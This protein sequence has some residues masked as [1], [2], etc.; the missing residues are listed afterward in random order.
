MVMLASIFLS[1][2][3]L[4]LLRLRGSDTPLLAV[5]AAGVAGI[6]IL[7]G[8]LEEAPDSF[9]GPFIGIVLVN[10]RRGLGRLGDDPPAGRAF[11]RRV[12]RRLFARARELA[13]ARGARGRP[14]HSARDAALLGAR[15]RLARAPG[16]V[17]AGDRGRRRLLR[18]PAGGRGP[19]GRRRRR[20]RRARR[21]ERTAALRR[22]R[23]TPP[24]ALR[25]RPAARRRRAAESAGAR[26]RRVAPLHEP[27][28]GALRSHDRAACRS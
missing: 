2:L 1:P 20:R 6:R 9:W 3:L 27:G 5:G 4:L 14:R 15:R 19:R 21:R 10:A 11:R 23:R 12:E 18:L 16:D 24:A 26:Q 28:G 8:G 22:A 7:A 25:P 13:H 17:A